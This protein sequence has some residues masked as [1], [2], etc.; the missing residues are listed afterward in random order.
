MPDERTFPEEGDSRCIPA[1]LERARAKY[2]GDPQAP[3]GGCV[4]S[5]GAPR[6]AV[7]GDRPPGHRATSSRSP[8]ASLP[9]SPGR[10]AEQEAPDPLEGEHHQEPVRPS[11]QQL[12]HAWTSE[13]RTSA[14]ANGKM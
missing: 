12:G 7:R 3:Q 4:R 10:T 2:A 13:N 8:H 1:L 9:G 6:A 5:G 11:K 14:Y